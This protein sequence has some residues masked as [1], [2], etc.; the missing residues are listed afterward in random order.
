MTTIDYRTPDELCRR[1]RY[2]RPRHRADLVLASL[3]ATDRTRAERRSECGIID[4][5]VLWWL[6][7]RGIVRQTG[8][9]RLWL[10]SVRQQ[11][12]RDGLAVRICGYVAA[13]SLLSG[14]AIAMASAGV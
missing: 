4:G 1:V 13:A 8:S 14:A 12:L 11:K 6:R 2:H 5:P 7:W 3:D 10:D 9:G